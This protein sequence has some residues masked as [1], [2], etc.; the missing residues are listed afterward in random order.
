MEYFHSIRVT[1]IFT[2]RPNRNPHPLPRSHSVGLIPSAYS[3]PPEEGT[4]FSTQAMHWIDSTRGQTNPGFGA[5]LRSDTQSWL[6]PLGSWGC[7][8]GPSRLWL[9]LWDVWASYGLRPLMKGCT[10][11]GK[12]GWQKVGLSGG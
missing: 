9:Y 1:E 3:F 2:L 6:W 7:Q 5:T 4:H 10:S 12:N 11:P 8:P